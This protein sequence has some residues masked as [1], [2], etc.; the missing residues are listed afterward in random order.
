MN[1]KQHRCLEKLQHIGI[2]VQST[3]NFHESPFHYFTPDHVAYVEVGEGYPSIILEG[4]TIREKPVDIDLKP[5]T[6]LQVKLS[7]RYLVKILEACDS[8]NVILTVS[9]SR[10]YPNPLMISASVGADLVTGYIAPIID[11]EEKEDDGE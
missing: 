5:D 7:R 6:A 8:D 2:T 3:D 1:T 11:P 10:G 9:E 4:R